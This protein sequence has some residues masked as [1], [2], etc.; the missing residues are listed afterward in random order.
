MG[1]L[2]SASRV[3]ATSHLRES[4]TFGFSALR[5]LTSNANQFT[6]CSDQQAVA[7]DGWRGQRASLE[8]V[9]SQAAVPAAGGQHVRGAGFVDGQDVAVD[10]QGRSREVSAEAAA[11][12]EIAVACVQATGDSR[13][14]DQVQG[15]LDLQGSGVER[16]RLGVLPGHVRSGDV[17]TATGTNC[18]QAGVVV[19]GADVNQ[20]AA[21]RPGHRSGDNRVSCVANPPQF[22]TA[23]GVVRDDPVATG[24]DHLSTVAGVQD[25][26]G[27]VGVTPVGPGLSPA[28]LTGATVERDDE[29]GR[30]DP[31]A[32]Q[33]V[34]EG[35]G[36]SVAG[37]DQQVADDHR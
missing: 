11:P 18:Q 7:R 9:E 27:R 29:L 12:A 19:P 23:G 6:V 32:T 35:A 8:P 20:P 24:A 21:G 10:Q 14:V 30:C 13:I 33:A 17:T 15:I 37:D 26:R 31:R 28:W 4:V 2:Q 5:S 36:E 25:R 34:V 22:A 16:Y 1:V 3:V